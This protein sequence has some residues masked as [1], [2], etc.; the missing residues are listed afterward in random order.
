MARLIE[1][2]ER[3]IN[4]IFN[5]PKPYSLDVYQRDY[6][7]SDDKDYKIVSQLLWDIE[8]RFEH[9][10]KY[11]RR[12]KSDKLEDILKVTMTSFFG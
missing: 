8:L 5:K 12:S 7:W 3:D 9:N 10:M 11:S 2:E 6:R 1:V 4:Y